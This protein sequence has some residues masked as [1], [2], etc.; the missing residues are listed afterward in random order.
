MCGAAFMTS[1]QP[2]LFVARIAFVS[3][4]VILGLAT[5]CSKAPETGT[6]VSAEESI[7]ASPESVPETAPVVAIPVAPK[8][9]EVTEAEV[10]NYVADLNAGETLVVEGMIHE[11]TSSPRT[12]REKAEDL[13]AMFPRL[14]PDDQRK[15]A[16]AA[17]RQAGEANY[18][19]IQ[20]H[21]LNS[22]L[23][24]QVLNVFMSDMLKRKSPI[25]LPTLL[26]LARGDGHPLQQESGAMLRALLNTDQGTNWTSW[27]RVV[28][29]RLASEANGS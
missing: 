13:L 17:I 4:A 19:V 2:P 1:N 8:L 15:V 7:V 26:E 28:E 25:K 11:I 21:L 23:D 27:E 9:E 3:I 16:L 12:A 24:P 10:T 14:E 5:G 22:T 6:A 29:M 20:P 18:D